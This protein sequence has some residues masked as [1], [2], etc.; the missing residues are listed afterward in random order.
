MGG[1]AEHSHK[2]SGSGGSHGSQG[3]KNDEFGLA[4]NKWVSQ[5]F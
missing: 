4:K 2:R 3:G 5:L 1:A